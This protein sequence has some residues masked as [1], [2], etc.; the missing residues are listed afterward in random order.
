MLWKAI[1]GQLK[2][3]QVRFLFLHIMR[4]QVV[5]AEDAGTKPCLPSS[6]D[7]LFFGKGYSAQILSVTED[8]VR[9]V[10]SQQNEHMI[11]LHFC[12]DVGELNYDFHTGWTV[13]FRKSNADPP[14]VFFFDSTRMEFE[15]VELSWSSL[16][17]E[18]MLRHN[19]GI[20]DLS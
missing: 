12:R 18:L 16:L 13:G 15:S 11:D 3:R 4:E 17:N 1:R 14:W 19:W 2:P 5:V 9:Y 7:A 6:E 8:C 20:D 10:D